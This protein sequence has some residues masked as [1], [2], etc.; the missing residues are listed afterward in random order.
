MTQRQA[1]WRNAD[2]DDALSRAGGGTPGPPDWRSVQK[3][4]HRPP[5]STRMFRIEKNGVS[6]HTGAGDPAPPPPSTRMFRHPVFYDTKHTGAETPK[7]AKPRIFL[8]QRAS[9]QECL[10]NPKPPP[11]SVPPHQH[12]RPIQPRSLSIT[13]N[14][15]SLE[16]LRLGDHSSG[17]DAPPQARCRHYTTNAHPA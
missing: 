11:K 13:R 9:H 14:T 1:K 6:E 4:T 7:S 3:K 17:T 16:L 8:C 2:H 15:T 12:R 10:A 5:R